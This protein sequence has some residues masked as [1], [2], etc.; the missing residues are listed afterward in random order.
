MHGLFD[1]LGVCLALYTLHAAFTGSVYAKHRAWGRV[2]S[3][4]D[5]A[6]YFW[7]IIALYAGLSA[8]LVVYF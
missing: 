5:E 6:G 7:V 4:A 1:L 8:L 2:V 3:R